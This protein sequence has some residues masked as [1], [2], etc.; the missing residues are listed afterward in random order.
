MVLI[1]Y[2]MKFSYIDQAPQL[3]WKLASSRL[4]E[5]HNLNTSPDP[6]LT[7]PFS[8]MVTSA[9]VFKFNIVAHIKHIQIYFSKIQRSKYRTGKGYVRAVKVSSSYPF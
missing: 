2:Y 8:T 7:T 5:S 4:N 1:E 9:K 3:L 6:M